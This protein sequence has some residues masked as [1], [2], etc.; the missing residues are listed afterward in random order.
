MCWNKYWPNGSNLE[1]EKEKNN[2]ALTNSANSDGFSSVCS[3]SFF[4]LALICQSFYF[5]SFILLIYF[6]LKEWKKLIKR[7]K[8]SLKRSKG[9]K[10]VEKVKFNQK[11][12]FILTVLIK[13]AT[14]DIISFSFDLFQT[15]RLNLDKLNFAAAIN[16]DSKFLDLKFD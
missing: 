13:F 4:F 9:S 7:S 16:F 11:S 14:F 3:C 8:K 10:E 5:L 6:W 12:W 15:F 2:S 1:K